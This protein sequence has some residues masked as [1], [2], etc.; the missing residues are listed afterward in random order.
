MKI[1]VYGSGCAKCQQTEAL[2]RRVVAEA[3]LEAEIVKVSDLREMSAAGILMTPA[4]A[5]DGTV[6]IAGRVPKAEEVAT[7]IGV[8]RKG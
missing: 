2:I 1:T 7:W 4:V 3:D 6:K 5:V 8:T